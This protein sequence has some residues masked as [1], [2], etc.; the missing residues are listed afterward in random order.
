MQGFC[1]RLGLPL[2][3]PPPH[4]V[5]LYRLP[6]YLLPPHPLPTRLHLPRLPPHLLP[7]PY[8]LPTHLYRYPHTCLLH[9][10]NLWQQTRY[11]RYQHRNLVLFPYPLTPS[12]D[13]PFYPYPSTQ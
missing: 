12:R 10:R 2:H 3:L 13:P 6:L 1:P 8:R 4:L 11:S 7:L 9:P 5:L